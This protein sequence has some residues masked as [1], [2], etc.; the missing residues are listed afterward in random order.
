[1]EEGTEVI[2]SSSS[3]PSSS[4]SVSSIYQQ[5]DLLEK[6]IN[7]METALLKKIDILEY[8]LK[9]SEFIKKHS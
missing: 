7:K 8:K 4:L 3:S 6:R 5:L 9:Y 1:M 2:E